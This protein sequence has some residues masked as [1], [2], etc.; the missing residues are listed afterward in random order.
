MKVVI[1]GG[2]GQVGTVLSRAFHERG[3]EVV[4]LSRTQTNALPWR[5]VKWDGEKLGDWV[6]ETEGADAVINLAGQSVN[7]RYTAENRR[8]IIDSRVNSTR[9]VGQAIA[10]TNNAPRVWL[11]ASTATLYAHRYDA[12]NDEANGI[13][14]GSEPDAPETWRFSIDVVKKW[15]RELNAAATPNT[16]RVLMRSAIVMSPG[17]GGPFDMLLRLVRF[18][19]GGRFGDGREFVSWIHDQ[20]FVLAVDWLIHHEELEG[21]VNLASP[22]PLPNSEF[23]QALRRAWGVPFALPATEWML[24]L[25]A[26]VLRSETELMLKSRRVVPTRLLQSGF[27]FQFPVWTAAAGDL[28]ARWRQKT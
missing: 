23:M 17:R 24:E 8:R 6:S 4:V 18:G 25:G 19:L 20:D 3:D 5:V 15:E 21:P 11:Q 28:C 14:G 9:V 12:P 1:P 2:S 27:S 26:F 22:N 16:R 7:C 13:I 10:E